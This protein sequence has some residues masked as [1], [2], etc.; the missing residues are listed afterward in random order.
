MAY[1]SQSRTACTDMF[2][3]FQSKIFIRT[4]IKK[5]ISKFSN[6]IESIMKH[7]EDSGQKQPH[8]HGLFVMHE[9]RKT[10]KNNSVNCGTHSVK[11]F[12]TLFV[13]LFVKCWSWTSSFAASLF[14]TGGDWV[15]NSLVDVEAAAVYNTQC[16]WVSGD[17]SASPSSAEKPELDWKICKDL[18]ETHRSLPLGTLQFGT[19][20]FHIFHVWPRL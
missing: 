15:F 6:R 7:R 4:L 20:T 3:I 1:L 12:V 10:S 17:S 16:R 11:L 9:P 13:Q 18:C 5:S 19:A 14:L 2:N 8:L